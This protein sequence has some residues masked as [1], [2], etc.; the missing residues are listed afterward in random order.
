MIFGD[1]RDYAAVAEQR[2]LGVHFLTTL[3][4][5]RRSLVALATCVTCTAGWVAAADDDAFVRASKG[6]VMSRSMTVKDRIAAADALARYAPRAA[7]PILIEALNETSEPVRRAAA[8]GLWTV[9]QSDIP[10]VT[11]TARSAM[12]A[13][14]TTLSDV[15]VSVAMNATEALERL[16]ELATLLAE[17][18]HT[19]S[20]GAWRR[21]RTARS[22]W[23]H[24]ARLRQ[25]R[26]PVRSAT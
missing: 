14:R 12:P 22:K 10:E 18:R 25:G 3:N 19:A 5:I 6:I 2:P 9:A 17:Y 15:R 16:G 26:V 11:T 4:A 23:F 7:V 8:R 1:A 21:P 20:R 24:G 13:L